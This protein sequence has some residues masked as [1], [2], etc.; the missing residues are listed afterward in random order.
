MEIQARHTKRN[1]SLTRLLAFCGIVGPI[2][3]IVVILVFGLLQPGYDPTRQYM[4]ELG[5][6][7]APNAI[8]FIMPE[9]LLGLMMI[10]FAFGLHRGISEGKSSK[11]VPLLIAV[12]GVGWLGASIFRCDVG[13]VNVS[14]SGTMHGIFGIFAVPPLLIAPTWTRP[15]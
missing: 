6:V 1:D 8:A 15:D 3:F 2:Q 4:S 13:C 11:F 10:A 14:V 12:S 7:G 5:A 9:F